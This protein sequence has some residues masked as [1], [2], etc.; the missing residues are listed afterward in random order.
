[1]PGIDE[2]SEDSADLFQEYLG[3][4]EEATADHHHI[5]GGFSLTLT[6]R[7]SEPHAYT[8]ISSSWRLAY[9]IKIEGAAALCSA[10]G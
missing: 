7:S 1:M 10:R 8:I 5:A 4:D 9:T 6:L 3:Y 2:L